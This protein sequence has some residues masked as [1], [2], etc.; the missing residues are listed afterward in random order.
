MGEERD[1]DNR[2]YRVF[3]GLEEFRGWYKAV[4]G[5][6]DGG[7]IPMTW[8]PNYVGVSRAAVYKRVKEGRLTA[9]AFEVEVKGLLR[10]VFDETAKNQYVLVPMEEVGRWARAMDQRREARERRK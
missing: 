4:T 1:E 6:I 8:V 2:I 3:G 5:K 10:R 7:V 9:F